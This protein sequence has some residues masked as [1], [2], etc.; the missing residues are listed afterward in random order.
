MIICSAFCVCVWVGGSARTH[1]YLSCKF[2]RGKRSFKNG[3][4]P[5]VP[6]SLPQK[7]KNLTILNS[8]FAPSRLVTLTCI[9]YYLKIFYR[10]R[11]SDWIQAL[12]HEL[13]QHFKNSTSPYHCFCYWRSPRD[14]FLNHNKTKRNWCKP[15]LAI[16]VECL[17]LHLTFPLK[18]EMPKVMPLIVLMKA[19]MISMLINNT[20]TYCNS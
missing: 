20:F 16:L 7:K 10:E 8:D 6:E 9:T 12:P 13:T 1:T 17:L 4:R 2:E 14:Q 11:P 15:S 18:F 19:L 3:S 5:S